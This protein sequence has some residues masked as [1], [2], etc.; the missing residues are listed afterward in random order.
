[1]EVGLN[2]MLGAHVIAT[3]IHRRVLVTVLTLDPDMGVMN[4]TTMDQQTPN[5]KNVTTFHVQVLKDLSTVYM[6]ENTLNRK[7]RSEVI[8]ATTLEKVVH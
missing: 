8:Q 7:H 1:M 2:G 6:E 5:Q 3:M 4:V